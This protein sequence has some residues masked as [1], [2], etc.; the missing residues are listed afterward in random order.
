MGRLT[1]LV[2]SAAI[3]T[4]ASSFAAEA[5]GHKS[6]HGNRVPVVNKTKSV[7]IAKR[8]DHVMLNPQPLPPKYK[9]RLPRGSR[10]LRAY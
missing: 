7:Q 1:E 6:Y 3:V 5:A 2:L 9:I 10:Y 8:P 4:L